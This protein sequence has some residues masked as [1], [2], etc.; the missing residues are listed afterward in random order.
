MTP[1]ANM[2]RDDEVHQKQ[3]P[4][5]ENLGNTIHNSNDHSRS[6]VL[7]RTAR[8]TVVLFQ[9]VIIRWT[10]LTVSPTSLDTSIGVATAFRPNLLPSSL[11]A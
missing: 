5:L 3:N 7:G 2:L 9:P 8:S 11:L 4:E 6:L 10:Y 1:L